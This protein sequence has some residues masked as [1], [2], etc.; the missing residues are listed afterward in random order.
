MKQSNSRLPKNILSGKFKYF[1]NQKALDKVLF[2]TQNV[3]YTEWCGFIYY[4]FKGNIEDVNNMEIEVIDMFPLSIDTPGYTEANADTASLAVPYEGKN[5]YY[6]FAKKKVYKGF[7]HSHHSMRTTFS[8]TDWDE[9]LDSSERYPFL[10][11]VV[12]NVMQPTAWL[13]IKSESESTIKRDRA[14]SFGQIQ[15]SSKV[16]DT[17]EGSYTPRKVEYNLEQEFML[18]YDRMKAQEQEKKKLAKLKPKT[19]FTN[20]FQ[21]GIDITASDLFDPFDIPD[22]EALLAEQVLEYLEYQLGVERENISFFCE[23]DADFCIQTANL[24]VNKCTQLRYKQ[25]E[26]CS[27]MDYMSILGVSSEKLKVN[28]CEN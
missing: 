9:F 7:I 21:S 22:Q 5:A 11:I 13:G 12:N 27:L 26:I 16:I 18:E 28:V 25:G 4:T 3:H 24:I 19:K 8:G 6:N 14:F 1:F 23:S 15:V 17:W 2:L 10:S 20:G